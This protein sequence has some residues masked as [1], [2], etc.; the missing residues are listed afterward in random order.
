M[1]FFF[2]DYKNKTY[3]YEY[4]INHIEYEYL[5]TIKALLKAGC[6][7]TQEPIPLGGAGSE[8]S[9]SVMGMQVSWWLSDSLLR[10][11]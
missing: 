10:G 9:L 7:N 11:L 8:G 3:T 1:F 4:F 2:L 5:L 6:S